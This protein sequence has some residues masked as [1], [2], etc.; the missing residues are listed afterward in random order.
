MLKPDLSFCDIS[1]LVHKSPEWVRQILALQGLIEPA[2]RLMEKNEI[3]LTSA[4]V[5]AN[6]PESLQEDLVE[7]AMDLEPA[8]FLK[9]CRDLRKKYKRAIKQGKVLAIREYYELEH[10]PSLRNLPVLKNEYNT[11]MAGKVFLD[12]Q[13]GLEGLDIWQAALAWALQLD[14]ESK[15]KHRAKHQE[16][17]AK[18]LERITNKER[19]TNTAKKIKKAI[20]IQ[21][22][23][24]TRRLAEEFLY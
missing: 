4:T 18:K 23:T 12:G 19:L 1:G 16:A 5:L 11:L 22:N 2:K 15:E 10:P 24:T 8:E 17:Q 3:S 6:L 13:P 14:E 9:S 20:Q 7:D 21:I